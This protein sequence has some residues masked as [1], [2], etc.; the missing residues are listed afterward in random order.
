MN[1]L[2]VKNLVS[3]FVS[4][5]LLEIKKGELMVLIGPSGAGKS[6]LLNVLAG[7][8]P[9][10]GQVLLGGKAVHTLPSHRRKIGYLFQDLYLF[11]HM[12]V[13]QNLKIAIKPLRLKKKQLL[14]EINTLLELFRITDLAQSYPGQI[15][16]G[17]KQRVAMARAMAGK[18]DLLLLDEPLSHLDYRTARYLRKQFKRVQQQFGL[19]TLFVTH[20]LHEARELGDRILVMEKGHLRLLDHASTQEKGDVFQMPLDLSANLFQEPFAV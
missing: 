20:D 10:T 6:S 16:G 12:T 11:P 13:F 2:V 7:F 9:H 14:E 1:H 4:V 15:S 5:D 19:T 17:E 8:I 3:R 18:P